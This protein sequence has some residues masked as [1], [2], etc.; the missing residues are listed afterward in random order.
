MKIS[1]FVEVKNTRLSGRYSK[2]KVCMGHFIEDYTSGKVDINVSFEELLKHKD[3]IFDWSYVGHHYK[4]FFSRMIPEVLIHSKKQD[5]R[6]IREHYDHKND[7][8]NWF[9]GPKMIYT[10]CYFT[11][12]SE[13]LEDAQENKMNLIA[14][15]MQLKPGESLLDIGCGWGTLVAHMAKYYGV[16]TTGVTIAQAGADWG[17]RQIKEYGVEDKAKIW[18]K[19]YRDIPRDKKY[20][21]ITCLEMAEHVG[22]KYFKKFMKQ[23]YDMLADDGL[24]YI[25][26]AALRERSHLFAKKNREDLVWGLFMNEYIF[27]GADA[28]MPLNWDLKRIEKVGFEVHSVENIGIHYSITIDRWYQNWLKNKEKVLE[29]YGERTFRIYEIFLAWS[30]VIARHGGSTA[31]QIVCRKNLDN[32]NRTQFIGATN[33]GETNSFKK[34][35]DLM[36]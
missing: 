14:Q 21:K 25:Q 8:F 20:D 7:L 34:T 16:E 5:E 22:I 19:D 32:A 18:V 30:V 26:I 9:L 23:C 15:K 35:A 11:D 24:F 28:S 4:F 33:M 12:E 31:Y 29:K 6:I 10:S 2:N 13:S 27:S 3:D 1:D 36:M 17:R